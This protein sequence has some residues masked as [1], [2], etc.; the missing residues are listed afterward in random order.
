[1][2][3]ALWLVQIVL[4]ALYIMAGVWKITGQG[5]ILEKT[6]PGLSLTLIHFIGLG[7]ALAGLALVLPAV[8]RSWPSIAGWAGAVLA[9]EAVVFV[10][11]HLYHGAYMPVAATL[12]LGLLAAFVAWGRLR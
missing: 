4:A 9:A 7:E 10:F 3:S 2:S 11:Y 12:V 5:P 8:A 1:M 6:M